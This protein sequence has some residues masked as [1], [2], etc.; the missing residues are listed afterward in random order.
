LS[1]LD[2]KVGGNL[3]V[4][5]NRGGVRLAYNT[6]RGNLQCT[7]NVPAPTGSDNQAQGGKEDQCSGL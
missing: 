4:F 7:Q 3:Q 2:N 5:H 1:A 6:I